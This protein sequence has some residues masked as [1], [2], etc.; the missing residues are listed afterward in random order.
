VQ[1]PAAGSRKE[2]QDGLNYSDLSEWVRSG[3][4]GGGPLPDERAGMGGL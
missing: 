3:A 4:A 1:Q 2:T